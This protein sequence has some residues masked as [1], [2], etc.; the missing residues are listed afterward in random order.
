MSDIPRPGQERF[1]ASLDETPLQEVDSVDTSS[2]PTSLW[3]DAW[4]QLR[5]NPMFIISAVLLVFLAV[6]LAF[7]GLFTD[8][9]PRRCDLGKSLGGAESGHPFG[10]DRQGCDILSRT[11][12][13][14]RASVAVGF[15]TTALFVIIGTISGAY[16]GFYGKWVDAIISRLAD[17]FFAIPLLL[18]AIVVLQVVNNKFPDRGFWGGVLAVVGALALFGW[19]QITRIMRGSVM[20]VKNLEFVDAARAIGATPQRNLFRHI[21][22]N[23]IA[24]VIVIATVSLG[25]VIVAE[26]TLSFLGI[27]LPPKVVSWGNDISSAQVLVRSGQHIEVMLYPA[28][29]LLLTVLSFILLGDAVKDALDPKA[30]KR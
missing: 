2:P 16:A 11:V 27:G 21:V 14:A 9:A 12:Y 19:P 29:A 15:L 1:V 7:P 23:A 20:E 3:Q 6:V 10:F 25:I 17:I 30:R 26:A 18:A 8:V 13:G 22:P 24:P 28:A 4:R 5:R